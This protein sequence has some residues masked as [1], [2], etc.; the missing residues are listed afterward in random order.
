LEKRKSIFKKTIKHPL[1]LIG[2]AIVSIFI[3]LGLLGNSIVL[4]KTQNANSINLPVSLLKPMTQVLFFTVE[5]PEKQSSFDVWWNGKKDP[6]YHIAIESYQIKKDSIY[7]QHYN[8][9]RKAIK[10]VYAIKDLGAAYKIH[11]QTFILGTDGFGRDV[12]SR[13]V[14]GSRVSLSVGFIA[15]LVSL[16]IGS[17]LG[18]MAGYFRGKTDVIISWF[19]NVIWSLPT[20]LLVVA[21]SF[22]IGKGFWQIF[23]AIGLSTW[24]EVARVVRG[25][26]FG[27][28]EKEYIQAA[29]ILGFSSF[30]IMFKHILPNLKSSLIVLAISVFG[31]AILLESGLS[32]LGLGIAPPAPSWGMMIKENYP[33]IMF[34][35]AYLAIVPGLVIMLLVM[36]F[37]FLGIALRDALDINLK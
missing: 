35:S 9:G 22:A 12:M 2:F 19:I 32:F 3:V 18:L 26:V 27:I 4:D 25:Q 14:L 5:N 34:D 20:M 33:Y 8:P 37:N 11:Q 28:R 15:V 17:T 23:V 6:L 7:I 13:I 24:V 36:G 16:L 21:V 1:G 10:D 31:S 29:R 30:R